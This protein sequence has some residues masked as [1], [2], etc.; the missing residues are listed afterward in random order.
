MPSIN[1]TDV[2]IAET[3]AAWLEGIPPVR[4]KV[5]SM[6]SLAFPR[7]PLRIKIRVFK[8][9]AVHNEQAVDKNIGFK[10]RAF[11]EPVLNDKSFIV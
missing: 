11:S 6:S 8:I 9:W 1:A 4:Q 10:N 5:I 3:R 7:R 2:A